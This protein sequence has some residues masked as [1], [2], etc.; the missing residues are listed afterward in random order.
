[1]KLPLPPMSG[2]ANLAE[3][4]A[5]LTHNEATLCCDCAP[6]AFSWAQ[7]RTRADEF[8][9]HHQAP[10][11]CKHDQNLIQ[12]PHQS[13]SRIVTA[14]L[15]G[16]TAQT[17]VATVTRILWSP[18]PVFNAYA[19]VRCLRRYLALR[20]RLS[21]SLC[22]SD[23]PTSTRLEIIAAFLGV[24]VFENRAGVAWSKSCSQADNTRRQLARQV[25]RVQPHHL[26]TLK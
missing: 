8:L 21:V 6:W 18:S 11:S 17:K 9:I 12:W 20:R 4:L 2:S 5:L 10:V 14:L 19:V 22:G 16:D 3:Q 13:V 24:L 26:V 23:L 15:L 1:M 25:C 7:A